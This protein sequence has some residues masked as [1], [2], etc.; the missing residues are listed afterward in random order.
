METIQ[1]RLENSCELVMLSQH[2]QTSVVNHGTTATCCERDTYSLESTDI[3]SFSSSHRQN[4]HDFTS[5]IKYSKRDKKGGLPHRFIIINSCQLVQ[6]GWRD[7]WKCEVKIS[8]FGAQQSSSKVSSENLLGIVRSIAAHNGSFTSKSVSEVMEMN[9][10]K[11]KDV[12]VNN[13]PRKKR[14]LH[15]IHR[16]YDMGYI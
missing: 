15:F 7:G 8:R 10:T 12:F 11:V 4:P 16:C 3:T 2:F 13:R 9:F 1:N 6:K 5:S 14:L